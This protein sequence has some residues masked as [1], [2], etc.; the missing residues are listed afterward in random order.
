M[1]KS[2]WLFLLLLSGCAV[3]IYSDRDVSTDFT[4]Y[5]T[6][7]WYHK[8]ASQL[9]NN[10]FNN[11]IIESNIKN[12]ASAE[13]K[14]RGYVVDVDS[15]DVLLDY[16]I[17]LEEKIDHQEVPVYSHPY[18]YMY[19]PTVYGMRGRGRMPGVAYMASQVPYV[20]GY[21]SVDVPYEEGTLVLMAIDRKTN[22]LVWK[23]W[24][25]E[26][27]TDEQSYE[28]ELQGNI[29]KVFKKYPVPLVKK[30]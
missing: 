5:K 3:G 25:Q 16:D 26:T 14:L 12:Y 10:G 7:A 30:K 19:Y 20:V 21:K 27:V 13:M 8:S 11:Q 28:Y 9:K 23:G 22:K 4:R 29:H 15:P 2:G 1:K 6:F 24:A 17:M 18:N